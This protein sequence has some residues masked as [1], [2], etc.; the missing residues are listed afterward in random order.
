MRKEVINEVRNVVIGFGEIL[1]YAIDEKSSRC[2]VIIISGNELLDN[3]SGHLKD[4]PNAELYACMIYFNSLKG[5]V[6]IL[7]KSN[8]DSSG[9]HGYKMINAVVEAIDPIIEKEVGYKH[10][11]HFFNERAG[12]E[13][14]S[15][16][17]LSEKVAI[18][19]R[20][21]DYLNF[22]IKADRLALRDKIMMMY[23]YNN[24][25][26]VID[27]DRNYYDAK[28]REIFFWTTEKRYNYTKGK[29][30]TMLTVK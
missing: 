28:Q 12:K 8:K 25:C 13:D 14:T 17:I 6:S 3:G 18:F 29:L 23:I 2:N 7:I 9:Y 20:L 21:S 1:D 24:L 15:K 19:E 4:S 16:V 27:A 22:E 11:Y 26:K 30:E 10:H 5:I